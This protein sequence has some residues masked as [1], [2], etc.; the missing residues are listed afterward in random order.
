MAV[1]WPW[2]ERFVFMRGGAPGQL[3]LGKVALGCVCVCVC[4]KYIV[5]SNKA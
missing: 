5:C 4:P 2:R 3:Q 1:L